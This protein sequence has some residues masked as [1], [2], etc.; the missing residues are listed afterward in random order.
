MLSPHN[1]IMINDEEIHV[2]SFLRDPYGSL[3]LTRKL[4]WCMTCKSVLLMDVFA[5]LIVIE[6][7]R[8][9]NPFIILHVKKSNE[10]PKC[11]DFRRGCIGSVALA[12]VKRGNWGA[13]EGRRLHY[14][15]QEE[16]RKEI[17]SSKQTIRCAHTQIW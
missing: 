13:G 14:L 4:L 7:R 16:T 1:I 8:L 9:K 2:E 11:N 3:S 15:T 17:S 5:I 10:I 12:K 6:Y